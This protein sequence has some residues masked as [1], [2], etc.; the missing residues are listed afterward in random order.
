MGP[1]WYQLLRNYSGYSEQVRVLSNSAPA[2]ARKFK[3]PCHNLLVARTHIAQVLLP[4]Q[5]NRRGVS[6][7]LPNL[8]FQLLEMKDLHVLE[9]CARGPDVSWLRQVPKVFA[10]LTLLSRWRRSQLWN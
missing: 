5:A 4:I 10:V 1:T 3:A 7:E 9:L 8:C 6:R 2:L